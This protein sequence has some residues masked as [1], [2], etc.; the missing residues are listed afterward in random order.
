MAPA[1][2][3]RSHLGNLP[4]S[5]A[6][7]QLRLRLLDLTGRNRL[8]NFR[9]SAGRA[10][11]FVS[12]SLPD[13]FDRLVNQQSKVSIT[14]VPEPKREDWIDRNGRLHPPDARDYARSLGIDTGH[15]L[16]GARPLMR[17]FR[18]GKEVRALFFPDELA[19]HCRKL[20]REAKLAIEETGANMLHLV[21]GFLEF[22]E[23]RLSDKLYTSPLFSVPVVLERLKTE[24]PFVSFGL[25]Y[26]D[27]EVTE[28]LSLREK[29][30][31]DFNIVLPDFPEDSE[32]LQPYLDAVTKTV[33][34]QPRFRVRPMLSLAML[35]FANMLMIRDLEPERWPVSEGKSELLTHPVINTLFSG[36]RDQSIEYA[37]EHDVD[38]R[39]GE[40]PI[41]YDADS[42]QQSALIEV[43]EGKSLVIEGPPGT[44]KSQTIT[45]IIA[46]CLDAG[47]SVLFVAEKMAALEVVKS[48]LAH[49]TLAPFLLELHSNRTN[50]KQL[51]A[52]LADRISARAP[53]ARDFEESQAALAAKKR[54]LKEY[55][56]LINSIAGNRLNCSVHQIIWR[57]E[58]HRLKLGS[59]ADACRDV[60]FEFAP[61]STGAEYQTR[62]ELVSDLGR[63]HGKIGEYGFNHPFWGFFPEEL[64]PGDDLSIEKILLSAVSTL[65]ALRLALLSLEEPLSKREATL[66]A[67]EGCTSLVGKLGELRKHISP[68][69]ASELLPRCFRVA[70]HDAHRASV[71]V[72]GTERLISEIARLAAKT[73]GKIIG[74]I[75]SSDLQLAEDIERTARSTGTGSK[76]VSELRAL[77]EQL[78]TAAKGS[79]S[80]INALK[81]V[82]QRVALSID[83]SPRSVNQLA[84]VVS[85]AAA[86]PIELLRFRNESLDDPEAVE[87]LKRGAKA[88]RHIAD[89]RARLS[90]TLYLD[91]A[92][93]RSTLREAIE[94]LREGYRWYRFLQPRWRASV[95]THRRLQRDKRAKL[96]TDLR[97]A[98]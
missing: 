7:S 21:F 14:P 61:E 5:E 53:V 18:E 64:S 70:T 4:I 75:T 52:D 81:A 1:A 78:A 38:S 98:C 40:L 16:P 17:P 73:Q 74:A 44:G 60:L 26:R 49:A 19:K 68:G 24:R 2:P 76:T 85:V 8:L 91:E 80:A 66:L 87:D 54:E 63:L 22:P 58:R 50:R 67:P 77:S 35:S 51:L 65:E 71:A 96:P 88:V 45:N 32:L 72:E 15:D 13:V 28:N 12:S 23:D 41:I 43:L 6:L 55:N 30:K 89:E 93:A 36:D 57:T 27:E 79:E 83:A 97:L 25:T 90:A 46:A 82:G 48:R 37:Q 9:H 39:P 62:R 94:T 92:P 3:P 47:K 86:A 34:D 59:S 69:L 56:T 11:Q 84:G 95:R 31:R 42:S 29:L 33:R 10:L 20:E